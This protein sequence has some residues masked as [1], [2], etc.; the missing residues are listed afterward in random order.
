MLQPSLALTPPSGSGQT[1]M[2]AYWNNLGKPSP[3]G[4]EVRTTVGRPGKFADTGWAGRR[5]S[6]SPTA[7]P[8]GSP[9]DRTGSPAERRLAGERGCRA[10]PDQSRC[11]CVER[12]A[13]SFSA[14]VNLETVPATAAYLFSYGAIGENPVTGN[15]DVAYPNFEREQIEFWELGEPKAGQLRVLDHRTIAHF[16]YPL[17]ASVPLRLAVAPNG[18]GWL[19]YR[20]GSGDHV[21]NLVAYAAPSAKFLHGHKAARVLTVRAE[22][23]RRSKS[24]STARASRRGSSSSSC[25]RA[26]AA[27][28]A[29]S[30]A[31]VARKS[32]VG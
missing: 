18:S 27:R 6:R 24:A 1:M 12:G 7:T 16:K 4:V 10:G 28:N 25:S 2:L 3:F 19:S 20:D 9:K 23:R 13:R 14:P 31:R 11:A 21:A 29:R 15:V 22:P 5:R 17:H 26:R 8:H 30:V 32:R